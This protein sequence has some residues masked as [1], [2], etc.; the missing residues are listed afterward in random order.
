MGAQHLKNWGGTDVL[1][2]QVHVP[3]TQ[4]RDLAAYRIAYNRTLEEGKGLSPADARQ[5]AA[6]G[7]KQ[8]ALAL[9]PS[10]QALALGS[11]EGYAAAH[12]EAKAEEDLVRGTD[13]PLA[14]MPEYAEALAEAQKLQKAH[15]T[16]QDLYHE[17]GVLAQ[18]GTKP[19][20]ARAAA[21][22]QTAEAVDKAENEVPQPGIPTGRPELTP[23][24]LENIASH[25]T[26]Q[27]FPGT[28]STLERW[29]YDQGRS[30]GLTTGNIALAEGVP[31]GDIYAAAID[32]AAKA[33]TADLTSIQQA[34]WLGVAR[35]FFRAADA[36]YK[37]TGPLATSQSVNAPKPDVQYHAPGTS[38]GGE[39]GSVI[40]NQVTKEVKYTPTEQK[41]VG[42]FTGPYRFSSPQADPKSATF[43]GALNALLS[44]QQPV[45]GPTSWGTKMAKVFLNLCNTKSV[46]SKM[47]IMRGTKGK[48]W[49][50]GQFAAI[51]A[52]VAAGH[53]VDMS[54]PISSCTY[55]PHVWGASP[56]RY[57][58]DIGALTMDAGVELNPAEVETNTGGL[59]TIY[60]IQ[61]VGK[62]TKIY[63]RQ[64]LHYAQ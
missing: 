59:F 46:P 10:E 19:N 43:Y 54:M 38:S 2:L 41:A 33:K 7:I 44:G 62:T 20:A 53:E 64:K 57:Y 9:S 28:P 11:A 8:K 37:G 60:K 16:S 50:P 63:M 58:I 36:A 24:D 39:F 22:H 40:Y 49:K 61:K 4:L 29:A 14:A 5:M 12:V 30:V 45:G 15:K 42:A 52:A 26:G 3:D 32:A 48:E 35:A 25:L 13:V 1:P 18:K 23:A 17:A 51:E 21:Y 55:S 6:E 47:V 27:G 31:A 56:Y 34:K